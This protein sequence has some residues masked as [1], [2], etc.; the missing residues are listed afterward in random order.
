MKNRPC[1]YLIS[2]WPAPG[3]SG[4][5]IVCGLA[6]TDVKHEGQMKV[7]TGELRLKIVK[8][9]KTSIF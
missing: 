5:P 3:H 1:L 2:W 6:L 7:R 4:G 8:G 9:K